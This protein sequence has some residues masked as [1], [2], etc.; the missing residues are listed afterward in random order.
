MSPDHVYHSPH[1]HWVENRDKTLRKYQLHCLQ[2]HMPV[3]C[4]LLLLVG[5]QRRE[6]G[7]ET[8][9]D[10]EKE[11]IELKWHCNLMFAGAVFR[12][13]DLS[14]SSMIVMKMNIFL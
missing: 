5:E 12:T 13:E 8:E 9:R 6:T 10:K 11:D 7:T 2:Y 14:C 4:H 1:L 3:W